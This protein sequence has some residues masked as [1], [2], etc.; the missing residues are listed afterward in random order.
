MSRALTKHSGRPHRLRALLVAGRVAILVTVWIGC[1]GTDRPSG[2]W[3]RHAVGPTVHVQRQVSL[4]PSKDTYIRGGSANS[5]QGSSLILRLQQSG[6][7]RVLLAFDSSALVQAAGSDSIVGASLQMTIATAGDNWGTAGR[8]VE[9]HRLTTSWTEGGATWNCAIDSIPANNSADCSGATSWVMG[10]PD[11]L[12]PWTNAVSASALITTSETGVVSLDVTTDVRAMLSSGGASRGWILKRSDETQPGSVD[13]ASRETQTPPQLV[14]TLASSGPTVPTAPPDTVPVGYYDDSNLVQNPDSFPGLFYRDVVGV[15]FRS[16]TPQSERQ[17]AIAAIGGT[18][19][20][21]V[22]FGAVDGIYLVRLPHDSTNTQVFGAIN[23]LETLPGVLVAMPD[24]VDTAGLAYLRPG[25]G[26]SWQKNNWSLNPDDAFSAGGNPAS[27]WAL[28]A[29]AAPFAWGCSV[30]DQQTSVAVVD[31]GFHHVPVDLDPNVASGSDFDKAGET[32]ISH[33]TQ[34]ASVLAAVGN[35]GQGISGMMWS[36]K[37]QLRDAISKMGGNVQVNN[38]NIPEIDIDRALQEIILAAAAGARVINISTYQ[39]YSGSNV[40][41]AASIKNTAVFDTIFAQ[42]MASGAPGAHPLLVIP[43]G[44]NGNSIDA[45]WSLWPNL[46]GVRP[47]EVIVVAGASSKKGQLSNSTSNGSLV[48]VAAPGDQIEVEDQTG[49]SRVDGT[50]Y[51]APIVSGIAGLLF[52]FDPTLTAGDVKRLILQGAQQG[53]RSAGTY[54]LVNAYEA[55]KAAAQRPG[56][57]LCGNRVWTTGNQ[58]LAQRDTSNPAGEVIITSPDSVSFLNVFHGGHRVE[59]FGNFFF[60][61]PAYTYSN[62]TWH[63]DTA[64]ATT[65]V[66]GTFNS[67]LQTSHDGDSVAWVTS[68]PASG[69]VTLDVGASTATASGPTHLT[70]IP[71]PLPASF[72]QQCYWQAFGVI[73]TLGDQAYHCESGAPSSVFNAWGPTGSNSRA[74]WRWAYSA[75]GGKILVAVTTFT[76][77]MSTSSGDCPWGGGPPADQCLTSTVQENS[78]STAIWEIDIKTPN[79]P[80]EL[81]KVAGVQI[82][83]L[84]VS[85]DGTQIVTAEGSVQNT[86]IWGPNPNWAQQNA[87]GINSTSQPQ[88]INNCGIVW[89]SY[90][91]GTVLHPPVSANACVDFEGQGTIAPVR[92]AP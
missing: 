69:V 75:R 28:E 54:P 13:F 85:E 39:P 51:A 74:D 71:V 79:P 61:I 24:Q 14:L 72:G 67:L 55:L 42:G 46:V 36:A 33:G 68:R 52:S 3:S 57:P 38:R 48:D 23:E 82:F 17:T 21:G 73:D 63:F 64:S 90:A 88:Q 86:N 7:N 20:G 26:P 22:Q 40:K 87:I 81:W 83:W 27:N 60:D 47:T 9:L 25:D 84:A 10:T 41:T 49:P 34:V 44:N 92:Q 4:S 58:V 32:N 66:G 15:M 31:A 53:G 29:V 35:N 78:D 76:A 37:L 62:G 70:N 18:V 2:P 1:E 65:P 12:H 91:T 45:Y 5:N 30:G 80:H 11:S 16:G 77:G 19:V 6:P 59:L 50:S 8:L 56:A 89:R 43:A